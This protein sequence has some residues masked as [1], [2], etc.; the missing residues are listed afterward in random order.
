MRIRMTHP[1]PGQKDRVVEVPDSYGL[2]LVSQGRA[3]AAPPLRGAAAV[4]PAEAPTQPAAVAVPEPAPSGATEPAKA[5]A[6]P[7]AAK[8]EKGEKGGGKDGA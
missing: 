6:R 3:V 4:L 8:R 7:A 1:A 5:E 2:R